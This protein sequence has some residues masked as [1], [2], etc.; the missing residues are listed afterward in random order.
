MKRLVISF[1]CASL[2][3]VVLWY[4]LV[5]LPMA[6]KS[7][8]V[9]KAIV[10]VEKQLE[11]YNRT[12]KE[13][14][15]FLEANEN[16]EALRSELN[17]SLYAKGDILE[18]FQQISRDAVD[19]NLILVEISPPVSELLELNRRTPIDNEP[20]FLNVSLDLRGRYV[21]FG[22]FVVHLESQP[23]FR[24]I[25]GCAVHGTQMVRQ[26]VDM[27]VSFKALIGSMEDQA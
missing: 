12:C 11:D 26:S 17:S 24:S 13:L 21:N 23:Y 18:L 1:V 16:L 27:T 14:P 6:A 25:N 22:R 15:S 2:G 8:A 19:H 7:E 4:F 20:Q 3:L 10:E 5:L 9:S